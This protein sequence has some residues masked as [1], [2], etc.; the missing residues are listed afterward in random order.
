MR[1]LLI[2]A[3]LMLVAGDNGIAGEQVQAPAPR[4]AQVSMKADDWN[5][6]FSA[7]VT[8]RDP[9][10]PK[11]KRQNARPLPKAPGLAVQIAQQI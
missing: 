7:N 8:E 6:K 9:A 10:K 4:P 11:G 2:A 1:K 5:F 3:S